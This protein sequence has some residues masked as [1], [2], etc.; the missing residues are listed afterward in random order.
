MND[1]SY[2]CMGCTKSPHKFPEECPG[3]KIPICNGCM[4]AEWNCKCDY[5]GI[6]YF[7]EC[8]CSREEFVVDTPFRSYRL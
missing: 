7:G 2:E 4:R 8:S 3:A 5:D 6:G 1:E